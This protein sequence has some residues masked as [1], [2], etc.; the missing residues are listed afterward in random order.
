MKFKPSGNPI[1]EELT[2][3][4]RTRTYN[5]TCL[6]AI[7]L[8]E[9]NSKGKNKRLCAWCAVAEIHGGNRKY[10]TT[11]CSQSAMAWAYP[12]KEDSLRFLLIRQDW[13][14]FVCQYDYRP[15]LEAISARDRHMVPGVDIAILPWYYFKRLKLTVPGDRLPEVDHV[16]PIYKGGNALGIENHQ[17]LCFTCHK[18]KTKIDLS[19]KRTKNGTN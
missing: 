19:G 16:V 2:K 5:L 10:C 12:Q 13:K 9:L 11:H 3:S 17:V 8:P 4:I 14:C 15:V 6:K 1:V 18:T 7:K